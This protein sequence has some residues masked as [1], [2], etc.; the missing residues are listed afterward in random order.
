MLSKFPEEAGYK[1][2]DTDYTYTGQIK[3]NSPV[4]LLKRLIRG[5]QTN[6]EESTM[7]SQVTDANSSSLAV[8]VEEDSDDNDNDSIAYYSA[9]DEFFEDSKEY[10]YGNEAASTSSDSNTP[11][12]GC[13]NNSRKRP[14]SGSQSAE[15]HPE[16][17]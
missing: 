6:Q 8:M 1:Y 15:S 16:R 5:D 2:S 3:E 14:S 10:E 11:S 17:R 12:V 4:L 13:T 7:I 9:G